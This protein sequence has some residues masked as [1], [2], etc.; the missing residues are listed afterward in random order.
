METVRILH[1]GSGRLS[2]FEE[3]HRQP[4]IDGRDKKRRRPRYYGPLV[5][6]FVVEVWRVDPPSSGAVDDRYEGGRSG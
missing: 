5:E 2:T 6:D 3:V 4:G 1:F